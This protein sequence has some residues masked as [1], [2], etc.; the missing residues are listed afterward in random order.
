MISIHLL[1]LLVAL[2]NICLFMNRNDRFLESTCRGV[3]RPRNQKTVSVVLRRENG[4]R[5]QNQNKLER[6]DQ[7][8]PT[9][10]GV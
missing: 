2:M 9:G 1:R 4:I 7:E 6:N 3:G 8:S 5:S 10:T